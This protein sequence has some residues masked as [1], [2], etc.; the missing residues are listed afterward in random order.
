ML[1]RP[2]PRKGGLGFLEAGGMSLG[3]FGPGY[4][5]F[6][7]VGGM[8]DPSTEGHSHA[9]LSGYTNPTWIL[10][11]FP[12]IYPSSPAMDAFSK[13]PLDAQNIAA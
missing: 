4:G 11:L 9:E 8:G 10:L 1:S 7:P 12:R 13:N 3:V 6:R 5:G 2:C